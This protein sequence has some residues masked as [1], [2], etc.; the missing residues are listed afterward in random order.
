[1]ISEYQLY[2]GDKFR[3]FVGQ[4]PLNRA[5]PVQ[6][7]FPFWEGPNAVYCCAPRRCLQ[8]GKV[9]R[10]R[11]PDRVGRYKPCVPELFARFCHRLRPYMFCHDDGWPRR[12]RMSRVD[13]GATHELAQRG[14]CRSGRESVMAVDRFCRNVVGPPEWE[15]EAMGSVMWVPCAN[16]CR[17]CV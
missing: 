17:V 1:M 8:L 5:F 14:V 13:I 3:H 9:I 15:C 7:H 4:V 12:C 2:F 16:L 11:Y 10:V 6:P